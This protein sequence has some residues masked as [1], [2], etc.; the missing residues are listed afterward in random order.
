MRYGFSLSDPI[1]KIPEKALDVILYGGKE[2]FEVKSDTLGVTR[3]L[4]IDF[5]GIVTFIE[6]QFN[7]TDSGPLKRWAKSYMEQIDCPECHG[8]RLKKE[9]LFFKINNKNNDT[10]EIRNFGN[11][12]D[13]GIDVQLHRLTGTGST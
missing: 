7:H 11:A 13:E 12:I 5:D 3:N 9:A 1:N 10:R 6:Q 8:G 2:Q 4:K